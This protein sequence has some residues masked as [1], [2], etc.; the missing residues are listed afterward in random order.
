MFNF[1]KSNYFIGISIEEFNEKISSFDIFMHYLGEVR[2][3][4]AISSPLRKDATPSFTVNYNPNT[5]VFFYHDKLLGG[6]SAIS[7][8]RRHFGLNLN[9]AINK[10]IVDLGRQ[11]DFNKDFKASI[12]HKKVSYEKEVLKVK[13]EASE[14][15]DIK[16]KT[17]NPMAH[18]I[19]FWKSFGI[20]PPTLEKY[21]VEAVAFVFQ[22]GKIF[23]EGK[24]TYS[25]TENKDGEESL[26]IYR[27]L[28]NEY[29]WIKTHDSS[30]WYG[31]DQ[32]PKTGKNLIITKSRKD[33]MAIVENTP[34]ASTGLQNEKIYPKE[35]VVKELFTRFDTIFILYDND[36]D[37][38][39]NWGREAAKE[40]QDKFGFVML[41]I[42]EKYKSKDFSDLIKNHG[43]EKA[44][45]ILKEL[46][47]NAIY[48]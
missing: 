47:N 15:V 19:A 30:V 12:T 4:R 9:D 20:S 24:H 31:W 1:G 32:L 21:G 39:I 11:G 41:E 48:F 46:I 13:K 23:K 29:K 33:I 10:V 28:Q 17:R 18:D 22:N 43:K 38:D 27:P 44:V 6:G 8:V 40:L 25:F 14:R 45:E 16:V 36:Y 42:H 34:C 37:K 35:S 3:G 5:D 7:F 26:T 2:P